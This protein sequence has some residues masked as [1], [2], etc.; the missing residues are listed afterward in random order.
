MKT[1]KPRRPIMNHVHRTRTIPRALLLAKPSH[2]KTIT[3]PL[4]NMRMLSDED[5]GLPHDPIAQERA[6]EFI[7]A[8]IG[9]RLRQEAK[10]K[11]AVVTVVKVPIDDDSILI[12]DVPQ[13]VLDGISAELHRISNFSARL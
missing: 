4:R 7:R 2:T 9:Y 10:A 8:A 5:V 13:D 1:T 12:R 6:E 3:M 11:P